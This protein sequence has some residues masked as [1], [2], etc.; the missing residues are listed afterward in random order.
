MIIGSVGGNVTFNTHSGSGK[1]ANDTLS[2]AQKE[3][4]LLTYLQTY[5]DTI[6]LA[7]LAEACTVDVMTLTFF[8]KEKR[9]LSPEA[10]AK[11]LA[12][13]KQQAEAMLVFI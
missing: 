2:H 4:V 12:Y 10:L 9:G 3:Q 7:K 5:R 11:C 8:V 13:L 6:N 1:N